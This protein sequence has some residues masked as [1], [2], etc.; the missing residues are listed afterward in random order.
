M[1]AHAFAKELLDG[2]DLPVAVMSVF[3]G[4]QANEP[5]LSTTVMRDKHGKEQSVILISA[6]ITLRDVGEHP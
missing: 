5:A 4:D 6:E 3:M 2:P 1:N